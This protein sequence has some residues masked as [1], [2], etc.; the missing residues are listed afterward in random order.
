MKSAQ[1][2]MAFTTANIL[3]LLPADFKNCKYVTEIL[4][5]NYKPR[6]YI[7]PCSTSLKNFYFGLNENH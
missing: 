4:R 7:P 2:L 6:S 3:Y 5:K 1:S